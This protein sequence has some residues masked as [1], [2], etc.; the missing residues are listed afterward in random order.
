[1]Q[2]SHH[3]NRLRGC[4]LLHHNRRFSQPRTSTADPRLHS[5]GQFSTS[6]FAEKSQRILEILL[7]YSIGDVGGGVGGVGGVENR[8]R[9]VKVGFLGAIFRRRFQRRLTQRRHSDGALEDAESRR[10]FIIGAT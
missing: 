10:V 6:A 2:R 4:I 1:M 5:L 3:G 7:R 8:I 9:G